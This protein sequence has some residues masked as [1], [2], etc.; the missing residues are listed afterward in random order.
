[1]NLK[2]KTGIVGIITIEHIDKATGETVDSFTQKN[3]ITSEGY[4]T[5]LKN[6]TNFD[7]GLSTDNLVST[8]KLGDDVGTTGSPEA[9]EPPNVLSTYLDQNVVVDVPPADITTT[10]PALG[11]FV[12]STILD[13][14]ALVTAASADTIPYTSA[15]IRFQNDV[16][17]SYK[18]F[19]VRVIS[20][21]IDIK[22]NWSI[23]FQN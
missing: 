2:D 18:R 15:T 7:T 16:S 12:L 5:I 22:I 6:L 1:M 3:V 17:L 8:I 23:Q 13:G 14:Q 9:P 20:G 19:P 10:Y 21:L 11:Q 4:N